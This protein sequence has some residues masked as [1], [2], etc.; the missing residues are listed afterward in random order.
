M[1]LDPT[2]ILT[3]YCFIRRII[4]HLHHSLFK[5]VLLCGIRC[6]LLPYIVDFNGENI[7]WMEQIMNTIEFNINISM[8]RSTI[9][10][11]RIRVPDLITEEE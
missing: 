2:E 1:I 5:G 10:N 11:D 8:P 6:S 4:F 7:V 3:L 9:L